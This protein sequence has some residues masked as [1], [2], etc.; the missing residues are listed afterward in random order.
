MFR[1]I[2]D[3]WV[4]SSLMLRILAGVI[5]G[6]VLA[7]TVPGVNAISMLGGMFVGAL[8]GIAPVLVGVLVASSVSK[9]GAG[10]GSRFKV[11]V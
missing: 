1:R 10:V 7:L 6:C 9:A 3:Y 2:L 11:V 8:K 4:N 5:V